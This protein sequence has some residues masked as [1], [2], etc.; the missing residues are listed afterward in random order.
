[1]RLG[2]KCGGSD[3]YSG[4]SANPLV[5][6]LCDRLVALGGSCALTEVPEMFGAEHLLMERCVSREIFDKTVSLINNFLCHKITQNSRNKH[7]INQE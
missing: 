3:G 2:L 4:I 1:L 7:Y 6:A 5:G